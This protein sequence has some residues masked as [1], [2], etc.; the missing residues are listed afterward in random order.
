MSDEQGGPNTTVALVVA[1]TIASVFPA[2]LVGAQAPRIMNDLGLTPADLGLA[3]GFFT[4]GLATASLFAGGVLDRWHVGTGALSGGVCGVCAG[5]VVATAHTLPV[6][7][8]GL[9]VGG[10]GSSVHQMSVG[11]LLG[12][13]V[14]GSNYGRAFGWFQSAKPLAVAASGAVGALTLTAVSWRMSF[15]LVGVAGFCLSFA[16]SRRCP[17]GVRRRPR[18][19]EGPSPAVILVLGVFMAFSYGMTN[20][21]TTF[22]VVTVVAIDVAASWGAVLLIVGGLLSAASR[23][24]VGSFADSPRVSE[25]V[26]IGSLFVLAGLGSWLASVPSLAAII[27][28]VILI[29]GCGW[30]SGS[31]LMAMATRMYKDHSRAVMARLLIG[32]AVG[33]SVAPPL[34]GLLSGSQGYSLSWS[35]WGVVMLFTGLLFLFWTRKHGELR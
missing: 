5:L 26:L 17:R 29:F 1:S 34:F 2:F 13:I 11:R 18:P 35:A 21:S 10:L 23:V 25:T 28:G 3:V 20:V 31:L 16:L 27:V 4:V 19:E 32:G 7:L 14:V 15:V 33:G 24:L 6:L 9:F 8:L 22:L 12:S 30:S